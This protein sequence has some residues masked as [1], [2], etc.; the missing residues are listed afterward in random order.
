[1]QQGNTGSTL[2]AGA[3]TAHVLRS[4][5]R[6]CA[7]RRPSNWRRHGADGISHEACAVINRHGLDKDGILD[8]AEGYVAKKRG[9]FNKA[10]AND[11]RGAPLGEN[12]INAAYTDPSFGAL[13]GRL[14]KAL[15][16]LGYG[17]SDSIIDRCLMDGT[18]VDRDGTSIYGD[19]KRCAGRL[20]GP[21]VAL[22]KVAGGAAHLNRFIASLGVGQLSA[23]EAEAGRR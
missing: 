1:M 4:R 17:M 23:R 22:F 3:R 21:N 6:Y 7:E 11:F 8:I 19:W 9:G 12:L 15:E 14:H 13:R 18:I 2:N 5:G 16:S 20:E 10:P